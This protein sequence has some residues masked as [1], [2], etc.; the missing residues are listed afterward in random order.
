MLSHL[1]QY[2]VPSW[3]MQTL[4]GHTEYR[5]ASVESAP[6]WSTSVSQAMF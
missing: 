2:P 3:E 4:V 1:A 5:S 6:A